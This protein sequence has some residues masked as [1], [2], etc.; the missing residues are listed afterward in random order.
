[1]TSIGLAGARFDHIAIAVPDRTLAERTY[2]DAMGA[3]RVA[4]ARNGGIEIE[5]LR[6]ADGHK[7]ELLSPY[8]DRAAA[9]RLGT[10]IAQHPATIHHVT[11]LVGELNGAMSSLA[12]TGVRCVGVADQPDGSR[13]AFVLPQDAGGLLVQLVQK[14]VVDDDEWAR[15]HGQETEDPSPGAARFLGA[16]YGHP[17]PTAAAA[18]L[19]VLG[20]SVSVAPALVTAHWGDTGLR[21]WLVPGSASPAL[22]FDGAPTRA[23]DPYVGPAVVNDVADR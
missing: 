11:L 16:R 18:Q 17:N 8:G 3:G 1:M 5:Q 2:V 13:E 6:F 19:S 22:V 10:H 20:A 21:L 15:R 9:I 14:G 7:L 23:A 12:S 4:L